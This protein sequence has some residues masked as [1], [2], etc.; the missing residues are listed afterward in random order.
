MSRTAHAW[1]LAVDFLFV[2]YFQFMPYPSKDSAFGDTAKALL[3]GFQALASSL[4]CEFLC[5]S[6]WGWG[7]FLT[8]PSSL[9]IHQKQA[10]CVLYVDL[11]PGS[12]LGI[13]DKSFLT[14][15]SCECIGEA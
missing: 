2:C 15:P 11:I 9:C 5:R 8:P 7:A 3:F 6:P 1:G 13:R 14:V 10:L 12:P 4:G